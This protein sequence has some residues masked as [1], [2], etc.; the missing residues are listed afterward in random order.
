MELNTTASA[1]FPPGL[2]RVPLTVAAS[3]TALTV[4]TAVAFGLPLRDPDGFLGPSYVRLPAL[5]VAMI[6]AD[7]APRTL[8]GRP[9][10]RNV[11]RVALAEFRSSWPVPRIL[12]TFLGLVTF[13][14]AYV[15]YRNMKS[16]LPF[17]RERVTDPLLQASDR[18]LT[19][20]HHP[21]DALQQLL[22]TGISA[23]V[24]SAVY[25][26]YLMFVPASVAAALVW[27]RQVS[28][29]AWYVS[30]LSFNWILGA[31]SYYVLPSLGPVFVERKHFTDL[32]DTAVTELADSLYRNRV[33]VLDDPHATESVHGIAAFASLHVSVVVT[34]ALVAHLIRV[35]LVLRVLLWAY[36]LLTALATIYFGWHY[37]V[38][39]M[40]GAA[41]GA[42]ATWLALRATRP[43][44]TS[45]ISSPQEMKVP[46]GSTL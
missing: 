14:L 10:L 15:S 31:A 7:I 8:L 13:Y 34:A 1:R 19:G 29:G 3:F 42:L 24:L 45:G 36:V 6:L 18:W 26:S 16:F 39:V 40:A 4:L 25:V 17:V 37:L 27:S 12:A 23:H 5:L 9:G 2:F 46:A 33:R 21:G 28:H 41:L 38:D 43:G 11:P 22:G 20:G 35:P 30:A 32:P 44:L